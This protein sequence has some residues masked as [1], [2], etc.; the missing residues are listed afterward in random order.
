[1]SFSKPA[2]LA[3]AILATGA[4]AKTDLS[5]C[6]S[7]NTVAY[8]GA[9]VIWYVPGTGEI[10]EALDCGGGRAPPKTT[11]PGCAAYSG[12]ASYSPSYLPGYGPGATS[13]PVAAIVEASSTG[14]APGSDVAAIVSSTLK[15]VPSAAGASIYAPAP[16]SATSLKAGLVATPTPARSTPLQF[17]GAAAGIVGVKGAMVALAGVAVAGLALL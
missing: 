12:T 7:S 6:T 4:L 2:L 9:S 3:T 1:M 15:V 10:C 5:G 14:I 11:V 13:A 16:V 8:G 17:T